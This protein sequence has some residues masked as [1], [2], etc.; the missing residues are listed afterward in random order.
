MQLPV[1]K[2]QA[3]RLVFKSSFP[4]QR[5]VL[6][7]RQNLLSCRSNSVVLQIQKA[8]KFNILLD[9]I[10]V[11]IYPNSFSGTMLLMVLFPEPFGPANIRSLGTA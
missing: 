11:Q 10:R 4:D 2:A 6:K 7:E 8:A 3:A 1:R 9:F 5:R